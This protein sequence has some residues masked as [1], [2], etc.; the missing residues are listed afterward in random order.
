MEDHPGSTKSLYLPV[1][2]CMRTSYILKY[3]NTHTEEPTTQIHTITLTTHAWHLLF[4]HFT[5]TDTLRLRALA[6]A[7]KIASFS[8]SPVILVIVFSWFHANTQ[9]RGRL[10]LDLALKLISSSSAIL[11]TMELS[12]LSKY[13]LHSFLYPQGHSQQKKH[14]NSYSSNFLVSNQPTKPNQT[15]PNQPNPTNQPT[16]Q[17]T[18]QPSNHLHPPSVHSRHQILSCHPT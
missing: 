8:S 11:N 16:N 14:L 7:S 4:I 9:R 6:Q 5:C 10:S 3:I 18:N 12:K 13:H 1:V 2:S 17:T 15:K